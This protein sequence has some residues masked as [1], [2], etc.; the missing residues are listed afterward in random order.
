MISDNSSVIVLY[1]YG[2]RAVIVRSSIVRDSSGNEIIF[3]NGLLFAAC[4]SVLM[5]SVTAIRQGVTGL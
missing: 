4:F 1:I 3:S 2:N 5:T